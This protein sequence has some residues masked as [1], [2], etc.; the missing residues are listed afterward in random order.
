MHGGDAHCRRDVAVDA[1]GA[2]VAMEQQRLV[3]AAGMTVQLPDGQ[4]IAD[5]DGG[6]CRKFVNQDADVPCVYP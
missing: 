3:T 6:I 1:A 4:R 5:E 2:T